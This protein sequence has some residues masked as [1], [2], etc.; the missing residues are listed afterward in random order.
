MRPLSSLPFAVLTFLFACAGPS[1]S[2]SSGSCASAG[3]SCPQD[4]PAT[5][6]E[7]SQC[8][9]LT[10]DPKCGAA[11]QAY[12]D[13]GLSQD[14]CTASGVTD[15]AA[16]Q[17]AIEANCASQEAAYK[18]CAGATSQPTCGENE[19]A[20]CTTGAPCD[21][22]ACCDPATN[23]CQPSSSS[24]TAANTVCM[25]N[26]C[27]ACGSP[28]QLCCPTL[29]QTNPM[30]C[31]GGGCCN[32]AEGELGGMCIAEGGQCQAG[33]ATSLAMVCHMASCITCGDSYGTCCADGACSAAQTY[34][35][36]SNDECMPCG[37][38]GEV[39]CP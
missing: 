20:C 33:T 7:L 26:S 14:K 34:C 24:C 16:S 35:D 10:S 18:A 32:Y 31:P 36:A 38:T 4:P 30:P 17:T 12:F 29:N 22:G 15:D 13:C 1:G 6:S 37:G 8:E 3:G 21:G 2:G 9:S 5:A 11:F 28:G 19:Q 25:S 39:G 27:Q 23:K